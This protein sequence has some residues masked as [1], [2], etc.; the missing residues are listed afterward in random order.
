MYEEFLS[1]V[2]EYLSQDNKG[3]LAILFEGKLLNDTP[4]IYEEISLDTILQKDNYKTKEAIE[5]K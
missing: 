4:F 3:R 2:R 5:K 1:F